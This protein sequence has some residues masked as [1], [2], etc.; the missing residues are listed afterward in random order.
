MLTDCVTA[1]GGVFSWVGAVINSPAGAMFP[2]LG[3]LN[4]FRFSRVILLIELSVETP[5]S[6]YYPF[7][8]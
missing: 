3:V 7:A 8:V 2:K 5:L 6:Y 1:A 4:Y